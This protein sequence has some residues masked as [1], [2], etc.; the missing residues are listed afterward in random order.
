MEIEFTRPLP[1]VVKC[2]DLELY[3]ASSAELGYQRLRMNWNVNHGAKLKPALTFPQQTN[4]HI[5]LINF[6]WKGCVF[7]AVDDDLYYISL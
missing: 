6:L 3:R 7:R 2:L 1:A 4:S 5:F